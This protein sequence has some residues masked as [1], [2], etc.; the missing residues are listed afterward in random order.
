MTSNPPVEVSMLRKILR[1][2]LVML[3]VF[4]VVTLGAVLVV[5]FAFGVGKVLAHLLPF[6][7]FEAT[8]LAL[9]GLVCFATLASK[10][11]ESLLTFRAPVEVSEEQFADDDDPEVPHTNTVFV[12]QPAPSPP[13]GDGPRRTRRPYR[14]N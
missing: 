12:V 5:C 8:L 10:T 6:S 9:L 2:L 7:I 11:V 3:V 14:K 13:T 1:I 4:L